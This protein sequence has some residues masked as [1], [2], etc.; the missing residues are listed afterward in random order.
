MLAITN[1]NK[2]ELLMK[3]IWAFCCCLLLA[4][5]LAGCGGT[6]DKKAA[7]PQTGKI[8]LQYTETLK[9]YGF[10]EPV[11]LEKRPERVVCLAH[12]PV[13]ALHEMGIR[14]A[15]IPVNRMFDWP[16]ALA[17]EAKQF[18]VAMNDNFDIES[19]VALQPDLVIVGYFAKDSYGKILEKEHIPVYYVDA[20]HSVPYKSVKE[21][22][23]IL[24]E[25]FGRD[26]A[27]AKAIAARFS[28]LEQR[29]AEKRAANKGKKV[30]VLQSAPPR[31]FI[32]NKE[33]TL[34][35]MAELLGYENVYKDEKKL[36][37]LDR[38]KA[39][40]YDPDVLLSV[41]GSRTAA[42]QQQVMEED[43]AKNPEYWQQIKAVRQN[44]IVYL[45][46][47]YIASA[48]INVVDEINALIDTLDE[49]K[50]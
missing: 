34:G 10:T 21:L 32:Q 20:G 6:A 44:H 16:D 23:E 42:E 25:A 4:A 2:G 30:M 45:P 27:G 3:K 37:L 7:Q 43:F 15:G 5:L 50:L 41:G 22:T 35:N 31:H 14:Q 12:T 26:N 46:I 19:V 36:V 18:N 49:K 29:L 28:S 47:N 11:V 48:G 8:V 9:G 40:S 39:I 24:M 13:L 1:C 33:G 17:K 38:E